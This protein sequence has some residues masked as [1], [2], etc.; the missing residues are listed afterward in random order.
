MKKQTYIIII[1][2]ALVSFYL[3]LNFINIDRTLI[4]NYSNDS[5]TQIIDKNINIKIIGFHIGNKIEGAIQVDYNDKSNEYFNLDG[6]Q[7]NP[8]GTITIKRVLY[9]KITSERENLLF[10]ENFED[11]VIC[12]IENQSCIYGNNYVFSTFDSIKK[13]EEFVNDYYKK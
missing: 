8:D 13:V 7:I 1:V 3:F 10:S 4:L 2:L 9:P 12:Q 5:F 11:I 6:H